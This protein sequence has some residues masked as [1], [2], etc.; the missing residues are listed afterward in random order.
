M[1]LIGGRI[2]FQGYLNMRL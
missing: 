1:S 2:Y